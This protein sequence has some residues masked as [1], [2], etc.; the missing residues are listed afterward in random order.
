[1]LPEMSLLPQSEQQPTAECLA[2]R[3]WPRYQ[4]SLPL[5]IAVATPSGHEYMLAHGR[6]ASQGGMAVYVPAELEPGDSV[7]LE[8]IFTNPQETVTLRAVIKNRV[9][10]KYG[11][12]FINPSPEQQQTILAHLQKLSA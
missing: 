4:V 9:G 3:R 5:R 7:T 1:M 8:L 10:F 12:E 11:V 2:R 6:D